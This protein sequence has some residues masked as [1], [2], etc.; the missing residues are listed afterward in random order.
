MTVLS[1]TTGLFCIFAV[2]VYFLGNSLF[3]CN[4]RCT[5]VSFY[6]ELT[7]Q[8]VNDDLQMKLTH[9]SNDS[10]TSFLIGMCT[11]SRVLFCQLY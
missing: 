10:L 9:T 11:E 2:Y 6:L 5:N 4:L 8:T 7:K 1:T 3:V